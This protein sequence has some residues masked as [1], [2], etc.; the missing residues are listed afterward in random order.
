M[1]GMVA[2]RWNHLYPALVLIY[3]KLADLGLEIADG[4]AILPEPE[5]R[6]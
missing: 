2:R 3:Q 1:A 6:K 4:K 5:I